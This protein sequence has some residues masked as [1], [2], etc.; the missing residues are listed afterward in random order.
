MIAYRRTGPQSELPLVLLHALPL[1]STM[2]D[3]VREDLSDI[4]VLTFDAPGFG[5]SD[6]SEFAGGEPNTM[7]FVEAIKAR[8]DELGIRRIA[9][10]GLSMGGSVAADFTA[11]YP[12]M[13]AGLALMDTNITADDADRKAFR[14]NV[15]DNA[16]AGRGYE[17][18]SNWTTTMVGPDA[19]Q[20]VRDSLDARFR[21]LPNEGLAWIQRAMANRVDRSDA[22]GM[23]E[24]P[25]YFIR[26]TEDPTAS[27]ES[28]MTLALGAKQPRIKEIEGVGHF[29]ADEKPHE[30]APL[31][32]EFYDLTR[33]M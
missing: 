13:V 4:D 22:V 24:G 33:D 21:A 26:G 16:D 30:L 3:T 18:V 27:M 6:L 31:L 25:V 19:P 20:E 29:A 12:Q 7:A 2:W 11:T 32:R 28:F 8:L 17:M 14:R 15:A 10:G 1:D 5:Q 23:V 9:L